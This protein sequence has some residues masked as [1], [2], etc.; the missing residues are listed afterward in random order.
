M[1]PH[2][3]AGRKTEV[4]QVHRV[5]GHSNTFEAL[6]VLNFEERKEAVKSFVWEASLWIQD[7]VHR[8]LGQYQKLEE[9]FNL[10]KQYIYNQHLLQ[11]LTAPVEPPIVGWC[12]DN[13]NWMTAPYVNNCSSQFQ[14]QGQEGHGHSHIASYH[15]INT[16]QEQVMVTSQERGFQAAAHQATFVQEQ[17][18]ESRS[19]NTVF[20]QEVQDRESRDRDCI[21][22]SYH[23]AR[24]QGHESGRQRRG[25]VAPYGNLGQRRGSNIGRGYPYLY[26]SIHP[27]T[28]SGNGQLSDHSNTVL[29]YSAFE[30]NG[31]GN[32]RDGYCAPVYHPLSLQRE[33]TVRRRTDDLASLP[34][35]HLMN[36]GQ[37]NN[38][39]IPDSY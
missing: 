30:T 39:N 9:E 1:A 13:G 19:R 3:P 8:P 35:Q 23:H 38:N 34:Q 2:F 31:F 11:S 21:P 32:G 25:R 16:A 4:E 33:E 26:P 28:P 15:A 6:K 14:E 24:L 22:D 10:L 12:N 18:P 17:D 37:N 7:P 29:N 5:F 36:N 20:V 27:S